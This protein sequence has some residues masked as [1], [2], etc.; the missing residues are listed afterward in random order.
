[1]P[2]DNKNTEPKLSGTDGNYISTLFS[3]KAERAS[4]P[5]TLCVICP[6]SLWYEQTNLR[7]FCTTMKRITWDKEAAP[8]TRCDGRERALAAHSGDIKSL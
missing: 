8:I 1:M 2:T 5:R 7:C 6:A 4:A 3:S